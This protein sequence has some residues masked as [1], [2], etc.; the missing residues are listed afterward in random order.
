MSD[1]LTP[2]AVFHTHIHDR[3]RPK[4]REI[5][6]L[7]DLPTSV[8]AISEAQAVALDGRIHDALEQALAPLF[9]EAGG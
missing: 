4:A 1:C 9:V 2:G 7:V 8:P 5:S 6:I 3:P